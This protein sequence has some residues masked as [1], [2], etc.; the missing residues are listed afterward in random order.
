[1]NLDLGGWLEFISKVGGIVAGGVSVGVTI[2]I[3]RLRTVFATKEEVAELRAKTEAHEI[4]IAEVKAA[5][6]HLPDA[7]SVN[8]LRV[9]IA[10]L[11]G[12]IRELRATGEGTKDALD[13]T[14]AATTRIEQFLLS[15]SK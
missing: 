15:K 5:I 6:E 7:E 13:R 11:R 3:L 4:E 10:D 8:A 9:A 12:E 14:T 1:M 2:L